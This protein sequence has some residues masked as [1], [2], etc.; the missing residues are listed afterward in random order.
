MTSRE[1]TTSYKAFRQ[2]ETLRQR[3]RA[4]A[5]SGAVWA[6]SKR[7]RKAWPE[8]VHVLYY[9]HVFD[10]ERAGF[11]RQLR[12]LSN[13]AEWV[14]LD[15]ALRVM[16]DGGE[17]GHRYLAI[18]FDDGFENCFTHAM[19]TLSE[20]SIPAAFFLP[21]D[22]VGAHPHQDPSRVWSFFKKTLD[23]PFMTWAQ[24]REAAEAG[25]VFGSHSCSHT[26]LIDLDEAQVRW[27]LETSRHLIE[28]EIGAPCQHF[29][30]PRGKSGLHFDA[31]RDPR[32][33]EELGFR[34]F[35]TTDAGVNPLNHPMPYSVVRRRHVVAAWGNHELAYFL[36]L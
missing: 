22:F 26:S 14:S 8:G 33:A 2:D 35:L 7:P 10:D 1:L 15:D 6:L 21:T 12:F 3:A 9:H 31:D 24:C 20:H 34:S 32:I 19:P 11:E 17:A 28:Q 30:A 29:C 13:H 27:E 25:F 4:V 36:G 18:T 5:R 23:I 16:N